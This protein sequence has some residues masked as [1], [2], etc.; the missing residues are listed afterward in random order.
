MYLS[1][2]WNVSINNMRKQEDKR[3]NSV[4]KKKLSTANEQIN[5][6]YLKKQEETQADLT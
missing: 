3:R 5:A 6:T 4:I 1:M 2:V